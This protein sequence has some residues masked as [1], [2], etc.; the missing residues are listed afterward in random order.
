MLILLPQINDIKSSK[1]RFLFGNALFNHFFPVLPKI[2]KRAALTKFQTV[3]A[4]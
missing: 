3:I 1:S 4:F 2:G